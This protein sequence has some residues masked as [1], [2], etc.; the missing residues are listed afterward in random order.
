MA[1]MPAITAICSAV[2]IKATAATAPRRAPL[3]N[4]APRRVAA[5]TTRAARAPRPAAL[6]QMRTMS[7][8][9]LLMNARTLVLE[10]CAAW[11]AATQTISAAATT[12]NCAV[13]VKKATCARRIVAL[14][15]EVVMWRAAKKSIVN[16]A[17]RE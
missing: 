12:V 8:A 15:P 10:N 1:K 5:M 4:A 7:S 11:R 17:K 16:S 9:G 14:G 13:T 2:T 6:N 3:Y